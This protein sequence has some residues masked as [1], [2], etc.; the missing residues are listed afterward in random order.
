M[1]KKIK[2]QFFMKILFGIIEERNKLKLIKYNKNLQNLFEINL[3]NYKILSGKYLIYESN[4]IGK[5]Y[6]SYN[7][8][9]LFDGEYLNGNRNG[10]G[11]DYDFNGKLLFLGEYL[12]GKRNGKGK[13]YNYNGSLIFEGEY[14]NGEKNGKGKEYDYNVNFKFE[15]E[16]LK[17]KAWNGK[18][19]EYNEDGKLIFKGEYLNGKKW[20]G[21]GYHENKNC[22]YELKEGKGLIKEYD[23]KAI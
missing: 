13:E 15:G 17:G 1:F 7:D 11:K 8:E 20:N 21:K 5:E 10:K 6:S 18:G 14:L 16:Y 23:Y 9:L 4:N 22:I 2:S 12:N 19:K 3:M